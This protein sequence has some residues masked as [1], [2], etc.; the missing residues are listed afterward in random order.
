MPSRDKRRGQSPKQAGAMP[1]F[2]KPNND[3]PWARLNRFG[4]R[5]ARQYQDDFL[6]SYRG[7][8]RCPE[9]RTRAVKGFVREDNRQQVYSGDGP[10]Q[11]RPRILTVASPQNYRTK[12]PH[13]AV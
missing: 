8:K 2:H 12:H 7:W 11:T 10:E 3:S 5:L 1:A 4:P 6:D 9:L 13:R